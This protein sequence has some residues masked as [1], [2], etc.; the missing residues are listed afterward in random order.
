MVWNSTWE[1]F[2]SFWHGGLFKTDRISPRN[3][4]FIAKQL[5]NN[6]KTIAKQ[7]KV[8]GK[9]L[10]NN[11]KQLWKQLENIWLDHF[12]QLG[13]MFWESTWGLFRSLWHG[14]LLKTGRVSP[15]N[16]CFITIG[17]QLKT[18]GKHLAGSFPV[19]G[20]NVLKFHLGII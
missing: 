3:H 1:L 17:K 18:I 5:Q 20:N 2:R 11:W 14:G 13:I 15:R 4:C 16:N 8:F 19:I 10:T 7:L 9:L 12:Q 6:C